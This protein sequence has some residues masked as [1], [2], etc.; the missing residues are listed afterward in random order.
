MVRQTP[1]IKRILFGSMKNMQQSKSFFE[2]TP[3]F[4]NYREW[5]RFVPCVDPNPRERHT[6][7]SL[8][9]SLIRVPA[10]EN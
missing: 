5:L 7:L 3:P 8:W 10:W 6:A 4:T 9:G 2:V 1:V